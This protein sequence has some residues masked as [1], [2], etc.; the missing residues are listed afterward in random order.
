MNKKNEIACVRFGILKLRGLR[1]GS[2]R[3]SY[4]LYRQEGNSI[5]ILLKGR[6]TQTC[7]SKRLNYDYV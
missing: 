3:G 2:E 7:I 4:P 1:R 6:K 5:H